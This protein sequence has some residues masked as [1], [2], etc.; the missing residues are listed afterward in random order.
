MSDTRP[1]FSLT[2]VEFIELNKSIHDEFNKLSKIIPEKETHQLDNIFI[3]EAAGITGLQKRTLYTKVSRLEIPVISRGRPLI[4][5][6]KQL[7]SWIINGRPSIS[8]MKAQEFF[9]N[10]RNNSKK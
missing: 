2:V 7:A 5:S 10:Q 1:L 6:R 9:D 4:F 3:E 8:E